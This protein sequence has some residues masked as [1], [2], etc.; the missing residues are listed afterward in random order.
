MKKNF[1]AITALAAVLFAGCTSSDELTTLE[2]IKTADN[3]PTPVQF[4]TVH[5][6]GW[7]T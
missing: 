3:T 2:S 4:G 1:L 6:E 7:D 5:G